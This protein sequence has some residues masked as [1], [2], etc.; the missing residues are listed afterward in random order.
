MPDG[1]VSE[2]VAR[3][4]LRRRAHTVAFARGVRLA[5]QGAVSLATVTDTLVRGLV[6]DA[7]RTHTVDLSV[8]D[9]GIEGA[10]TC[11]STDN[12]C[13]HQVAVAHALWVSDRRRA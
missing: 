7:D 10:C 3:F 9:G 11:A 5:R 13:A 8:S 1:S 4:Q 6:E 12:P 2:L